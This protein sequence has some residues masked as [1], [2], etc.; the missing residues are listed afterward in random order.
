MRDYTDKLTVQTAVQKQR[1]IKMYFVGIDIS[2]F[3]HDCFIVDNNGKVIV[4][5]CFLRRFL[6]VLR[7][8]YESGLN[9]PVIT[10]TISDCSLRDTISLLWNL[11][12][13]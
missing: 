8:K 5:S 9:L 12:H 3:K 4:S 1:R 11:T 6:M 13:S 7:V 10:L 2:K